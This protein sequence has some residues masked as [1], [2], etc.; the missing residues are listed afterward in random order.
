[1][2]NWS[3]FYTAQSI[4]Y[5]LSIGAAISVGESTTAILEV[6]VVV[7][8]AAHLALFTT[9]AGIYRTQSGRARN[10]VAEAW[11]PTRGWSLT[12]AARARQS[13]IAPRIARNLTLGTAKPAQTSCEL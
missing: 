7:V 12:D 8:V 5:A 3:V 11:V 10:L 9:M 13:R 1:M 4:R 6:T 2:L